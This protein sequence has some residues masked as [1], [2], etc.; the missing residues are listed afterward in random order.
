M[1]AAIL[2]DVRSNQSA[3]EHTIDLTRR[4]VLITGFFG[5]LGAGGRTT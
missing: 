3:R 5:R 2:R 4:V 1:P